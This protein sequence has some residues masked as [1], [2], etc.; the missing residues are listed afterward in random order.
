MISVIHGQSIALAPKQ[1]LNAVQSWGFS[2][3]RGGHV[4]LS[5]LLSVLLHNETFGMS[6]WGALLHWDALTQYLFTISTLTGR[7]D[8]EC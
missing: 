6:S 2:G 3:G 5:H 7:G 1:I 8:T 4:F